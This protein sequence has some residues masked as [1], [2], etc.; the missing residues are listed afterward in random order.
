MLVP[1]T[2]STL[3][4]F[5]RLVLY[6]E[7]PSTVFITNHLYSSFIYCFNIIPVYSSAIYCFNTKPLY[8]CAFSVSKI[9]YIV[10]SSNVST[11]VIDMVVPFQQ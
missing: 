8:S 6:M 2:V 3:V 11:Q 5:Q 4:L 10:V 9:I 1:S 7:A